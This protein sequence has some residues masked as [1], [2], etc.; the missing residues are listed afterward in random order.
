MNSSNGHYSTV[1]DYKGALGR[2]GGG[3]SMSPIG[4]Q[5]QWALFNN[6]REGTFGR[7]RVCLFHQGVSRSNE[8]YSI[9]NIG[10]QWHFCNLLDT[11]C[12]RSNDK[13]WF[14]NGRRIYGRSKWTK[15]AFIDST[16][17]FINI[18]KWFS[19]IDINKS[20]LNIYK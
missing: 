16:K 4:E 3:L 14:R 8:H 13:D 2:G 17:S 19:F 20:F 1:A 5:Q 11:R 10:Y 6:S 7:V 9:K 15:R 18:N 12:H